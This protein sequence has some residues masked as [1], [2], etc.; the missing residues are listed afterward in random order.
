MREWFKKDVDWHRIGME[1]SFSAFDGVF[2]IC[3]YRYIYTCIYLNGVMTVGGGEGGSG[4]GNDLLQQHSD[5]HAER[6]IYA[7]SARHDL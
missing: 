3:I 4:I 7:K 5:R 2:M 6:S 1:G